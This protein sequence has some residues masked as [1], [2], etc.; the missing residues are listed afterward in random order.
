MHKLVKLQEIIE[1]R[2]GSLKEEVEVATSAKLNALYVT[3]LKDEIASLQWATRLINWSLDQA[4][5]S[6]QP[7]GVTK[8]RLELE[9]AK[10][11]IDLLH[12][13]IQILEIELEDSVTAREKE[14]I[15]NEIDTLKC[16]LGH[17]FNLKYDEKVRAID[18]SESNYDFQRAKRLRKQ[19]IKIQDV[20]SK[21]NAQIQN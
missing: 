6:Q 11:F 8:E 15:V 21:I 20:E 14:V 3:D 17:L 10:K 18:I 4:I 9:D 1:Q 12:D 2:I 16:I 7:L 5:D 13:R 19:L